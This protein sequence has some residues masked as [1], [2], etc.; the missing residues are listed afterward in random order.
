VPGGDEQ[1]AAP[2]CS[3]GAS[4][5]TMSWVFWVVLGLAAAVVIVKFVLK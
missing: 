5:R 3:C 2:S 1:G 4:N